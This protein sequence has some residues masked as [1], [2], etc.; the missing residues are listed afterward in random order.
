MVM[1]TVLQQRYRTTND[2]RMLL[3]MTYYF[4]YQ[5]QNLKG[6]PLGQ[7]SG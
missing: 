2:P 5:L 4:Q 1:F 7:W 3:F 6:T